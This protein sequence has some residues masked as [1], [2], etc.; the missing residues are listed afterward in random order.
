VR[1]DGTTKGDGNF[2]FGRSIANVAAEAE[3]SQR[4]G[5]LIR[6]GG[7]LLVTLGLG[8]YVYYWL[9]DGKA[10]LIDCL[11]MTV[12]TVSTVGFREVIPSEGDALRTWTMLLIVFGG[13]SLLYFVTAAAALFI[14]GDIAFN[15]WRNRQLSRL[16]RVRDHTVVC[17]LGWTGLRAAAELRG[18]RQTVV[19]IDADD[20]KVE[21]ALAQIGPQLLFII[22]DAFDEETLR[23]A[24]IERARGLVAALGEDRDNLL[25]AVTARNLKPDLT[26]VSKLAEPSNEAKFT[27]LGIDALVNPGTMGGV[28]LAQE[29]LRPE[30]VT[31]T[32]AMLAADAYTRSLAELPILERAAVA[33]KRL[34]EA[35]LEDA[36]GCL[37][38]G[39]RDD[40]E[41]PF[42]YHPTEDT[43][44]VAGGSLMAL[45]DKRQLRR[46]R[47]L[48]APRRP[49][50][51][52]L[53]LRGA[54]P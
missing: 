42:R 20:A 48:V 15:L 12:I 25:L 19:V 34:S 16:G 41:G 52:R 4:M 32:D 33:G 5:R 23:T 7:M 36:T 54:P 1:S 38:M 45:G 17:G 47:A 13:G 37:V 10:T 46:L 6:A 43:R 49:L 50:L 51:E 27:N 2:R 39:L 26:I 24:G 44:L 22:G 53:G 18:S 9:A 3:R 30:V 8:T 40:R 11:Y 29:L 31:F 28:R 21:E 35:A 14:E